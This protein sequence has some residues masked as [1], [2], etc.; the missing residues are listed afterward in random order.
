MKLVVI[1][2]YVRVKVNCLYT[3]KYGLLKQYLL[4]NCLLH[5][6][7]LLQYDQYIDIITKCLSVTMIIFKLMEIRPCRHDIR[8]SYNAIEL[9]AKPT[10]WQFNLFYSMFIRFFNRI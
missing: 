10:L 8:Y 2:G 1:V 6:K 3:A 5:R 7:C 4:P 9:V